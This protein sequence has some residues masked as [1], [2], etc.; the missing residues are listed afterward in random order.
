MTKKELLEAI[1]DM[2]EDAKVLNYLDEVVDDVEYDKVSNE[3]I[4]W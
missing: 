4:I 2:P 1:K 3:I